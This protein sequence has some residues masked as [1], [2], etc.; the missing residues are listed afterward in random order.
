MLI[1]LDFAEGQIELDPSIKD[2]ILDALND[3]RSPA[4]EKC[5][6]CQFTKAHIHLCQL[7]EFDTETRNGGIVILL[8]GECGHIWGTVYAAHKGDLVRVP[9]VGKNQLYLT[10]HFQDDESC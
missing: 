4:R 3:D 7:S 5:P 1:P 2:Q 8:E 6:L 10:T 9:F